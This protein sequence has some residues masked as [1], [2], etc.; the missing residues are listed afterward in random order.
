MSNLEWVCVG[1]LVLIYGGSG[2]AELPQWRKFTGQFVGWGFPP[3]W[4]A[5]NPGLKIAGAGMTIVPQ[6]RLY[7]VMLCV[8]VALGAAFVVL[9]FRERTM[10]KAAL[11]VAAVTLV[12][13]ALL[14]APWVKNAASSS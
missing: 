3:W 11:P 4:A 5:F 2:L 6:T 7:G 12:C 14:L 8:L 10:L 1:L 13:A 9:R